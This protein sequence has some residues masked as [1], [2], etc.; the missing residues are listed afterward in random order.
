MVHDTGE[1][2]TSRRNRRVDKS[3]G[4]LQEDNQ[5]LAVENETLRKEFKESRNLQDRMLKALE[6]RPVVERTKRPRSLLKT[7]V[8]GIGGFVLGVQAGR[9]LLHKG[10][11]WVSSRVRR[12][13]SA[14]P[15][16]SM[17]VPTSANP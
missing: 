11:A 15:S 6:E 5:R 16:S 13:E 17:G 9:E 7:I 1:T 10:T 14:T 12:S 4:R 8:V 3:L 2:T